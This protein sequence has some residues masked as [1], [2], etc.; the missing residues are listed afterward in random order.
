M[1]IA[2]VIEQMD[3]SCGG[4]ETS[5]AQI[6]AE[7]ARR[8]QD[9]TVLCRRGRLDA[10][11]VTVREL[12][13]RWL[14]RS[15]RLRGFVADAQEEIRRNRYDIVHAMLPLPGANVYQP[16]GG[17]IP[18]QCRA[19]LRRRTVLIRQLF[20]LA[21]PLNRCRAVLGAMERQIVADPKV[22]CLAVSEMVA[23]E[24]QR[25]YS[26]RDGVRVIYNAVDVP[27]PL[28]EQRADW[29]QRLRYK[30]GCG[31]DNT[32]FLTVAN[33]F[34]LKGV[35]RTI[36]AFASWYHSAPSRRGSRLVVVGR[37]MPEGYQRHA[38]LRDVGPAVVFVPPTENV[39]Q[40]Y[41]AADACILLSWYDPCSRVV[42]EA[43]RWGVPSITTV[44]NGA[45]EV[46]A[47]GGGVV[48]PSP[49]D[50][51]AVIMA[52]DQMADP[53]ARAKCQAV[54]ASLYD[55]LSVSRHVEEL[56]HAY[57]EWIGR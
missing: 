11:G 38:S 32:V 20:K 5:T 8:G 48:V 36:E 52:M 23:E 31:S 17:T 6:A 24:F 55:R 57:Q 19:S 45:A 4:R 39:F 49:N 44:F 33:N 28:G 27:D 25:H 10:A 37:E 14:S 22:L 12:G 51:R 54:L 40:W 41:A 30:V 29:R 35:A 21:E 47:D 7:M 50:R 53:A 13:R 15:R 9:V 16:R 2:L 46:L 42:L 1:K 43:A 56:L 34:P 3:P 26:R 18:A